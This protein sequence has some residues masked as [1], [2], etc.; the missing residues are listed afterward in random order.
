MKKT[1]LFIKLLAAALAVCFTLAVLTGCGDSGETAMTYEKDGKSFTLTEDDFALLM[2]IKKIDYFCNMLYTTQKDTATFWATDSGTDGKTNEQFYKELVVD[3]AKAILVEKY[4]FESLDLTLSQDVLDKNNKSKKD[5]IKQYGGTGFYKQKFGYSANDYYDVYM[6][7]VNRSEALLE[8]LCGEGG[9]YAVTD[10]DLEKY[11]QENYVGYQFIVLDMENKVVLDEEGNRVIATTKDAEGNE[12]EADYY[13]TEALTDEEKSEKQTL[14]KTIF[15]ELEAGTMSFEELVQKYSDEYYSVAFPEGQFVLADGTF[16][17]A[18]V[19][20]KV[21]DLE[22]GEYTE[23]VISV[24]SDKYQYIVKRIDL[25]EK[26]YDAD[27]YLDLF[28]GYDV[29]VKYDKYENLIQSYLEDVVVNDTVVSAYTMK[30]TPLSDYVDDYYQN[31]LY[32]YYYGIG[33]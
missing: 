18:T 1:N 28:D 27:A 17:N 33:Q 5:A 31:Y 16:I 19:T 29:T 22:I 6:Q 4:L 7:M 2:K 23:E 25:K 30:D 12:T 24:D 32:Y 15:A 14:A 8:K 21:K 9:E 20:E 11:Y 10:E 26:V 3:Q 13:K